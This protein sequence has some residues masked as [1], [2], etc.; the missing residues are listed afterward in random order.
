[1]EEGEIGLGEGF[2]GDV[3]GDGG[4]GVGVDVHLFGKFGVGLFVR[5]DA[6]GGVEV[7]GGAEAEGGFEFAEELIWIREEGWVPGVACPAC[8]LVVGLGDV[9]VHVYDADGEGDLVGLEGLH[10]GEEFLLGVG[11]VAR[12]PVAEGPA[13]EEGDGAGEFEVVLEAGGVVLGVAE[14]V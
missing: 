2:V 3:K 12:P 7:E 10:E 13:G 4:L 9:P 6:F 1:M 14:E 11:P 8:G 5:V